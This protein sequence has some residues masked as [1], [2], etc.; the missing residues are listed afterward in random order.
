MM[1]IASCK[2]TWFPGLERRIPVIVPIGLDIHFL[3]DGQHLLRLPLV[4]AKELPRV[5]NAVVIR[6]IKNAQLILSRREQQL[7]PCSP[8][9]KGDGIFDLVNLKEEQ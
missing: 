7:P 4:L 3:P 9:V 1:K 2:G 6:I 5:P 8:A